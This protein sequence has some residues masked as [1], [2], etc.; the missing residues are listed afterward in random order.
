LTHK[1]PL[2]LSTVIAKKSPPFLTRGW[3]RPLLLGMACFVG[4]FI[5]S[6]YNYLLFHGLAEVF[7]IVV[8][9]G[10]FMVAWNAR[11]LLENHYLLF[12]GIAYLFV[13]FLDLIHT[14]AY[15]GMGVFPQYAISHGANLATELWIATR[16]V[17]SLSLLVAPLFIRRSL[18]A[19]PVF[20]GY[21]GLTLLLLASIFLWDSFPDCFV[22]GRG[23]TPFKIV[24]EYAI[25]L[26]LL[27]SAGVLVREERAFD[28]DVRRFLVAAILVT[29]G[30]EL[31]FTLYTDVYGFTN[32]LGHFLK[33]VSFYLIYRAV[34]ETGVVRPHAV[35]FRNLK[36][37]EKSL[38]KSREEAEQ[39]LAQLRT[40]LDNVVEGVVVADLDGR[41]FHW[42]PAAVVMHGFASEEEGRRRLPEFE[43]IFE[44]STQEEGILP[45]ERWP[46]AR[47]LAEETLC[48]WE[49]EVR[50][51][52]ADW[53][54]VF[55]YGG[56]LARDDEGRPLLAVVTVGDITESKQA[57]AALGQ[58]EARFKLLSGTAGQLLATHDPQGIVNH[59]CRN[60]MAHL[61]CQAFF[62][63]LVDER[64]GRL[65]LNAFAGIPEDEAR[66]IEWLDYG[67]AV[68]GCVARDG[69]PLVAEDIFRSPDIRTELVK[70]Y[71]I[72]AYACHP[73][74]AGDRLIGTLSF[75]T[76]T[77]PRFSSEDLTLM[78][79]VTD[80]VAAAMER[81]RL[82]EALRKN[83][84]ELEIRVLERTAT[85]KQYATQLEW[86]N[87][88]LQEF[89]YVASHDL[90]EPL[91]KIQMFGAMLQDEN[92]DT[93]SPESHDYVDRMIRAA[94]R[95]QTLVRDFLAYSRV[96]TKGKPFEPTDLA[97][98]L[99]EALVNLEASIGE[100]RAKITVG[101]LPT[102]E[103]DPIQMTQLFQNLLGNA[104]KFRR[105]GE[106]PTVEVFGESCGES[107]NTDD[108][109]CRIYVRDDGIGFDT[110][111]LDLIFQ[112]FERLH[113]RGTYEGTGIGLAICRRIVERHGGSI[114]AES[115]PGAG[116]TFVVT[117]P[118]CQVD[119]NRDDY[120][121]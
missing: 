119:E 100:S 61:D 28:R 67:V 77:R 68:C 36:E 96:S 13:G 26:I 48:D 15:K 78:K 116:A 11:S 86:R 41:L 7:S 17:E 6:R 55:N 109:S 71:G 65:H 98:V 50:R 115:A 73:L 76:K 46:L 70:S 49:V 10:I 99:A 18:R 35:V 37:S 93:L 34:I 106:P 108:R 23:L 107:S 69:R 22:D 14:L 82:I 58:S 40:I 31:S 83:R 120:I 19:V 30:E 103:A 79:T 57:E 113:G 38:R 80:Q 66:K 105:N 104:L 112:P 94:G 4:L 24:S 29:I 85:L 47:I 92:E 95:M 20:F 27:A 90:Q 33:I 88:E 74:T 3:T 111:Y 64:A 5:T 101:R 114:T 117:L 118:C 53:R 87:R 59:L 32:L 102:V 42:N 12:L 54:R 9:C 45:L 56:T 72:Q 43:E 63:F 51:R 91:R 75:G 110:R 97:K 60:V 1:E 8:A 44:L 89:A 2:M 39:H 121:E 81:I 21:A 52:G 84:T 16:Y 25:C 62:N